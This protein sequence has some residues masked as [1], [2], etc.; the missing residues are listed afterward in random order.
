MYWMGHHKPSAQQIGEDKLGNVLCCI[1]INYFVAGI[2]KHMKKRV[3]H[4]NR[5]IYKK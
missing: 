5:E 2:I 1:L 3:P 4:T